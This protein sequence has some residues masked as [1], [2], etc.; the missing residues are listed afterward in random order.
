[1]DT[2]SVE[3]QREVQDKGTSTSNSSSIQQQNRVEDETSYKI[4]NTAA[5]HCSVYGSGTV[6]NTQI[7][8]FNLLQ[9]ESLP[10]RKSD[11]LVPCTGCKTC[12][13]NGQVLT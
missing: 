2:D 6:F 12:F 8:G 4:S 11:V 13:L 10:Q 7:N 5:N 1:M 9:S 3:V